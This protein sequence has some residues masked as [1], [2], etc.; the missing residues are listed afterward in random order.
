MKTNWASQ[1][2]YLTTGY[3][4][5]L[6][7]ILPGTIVGAIYS[8]GSRCRTAMMKSVYFFVSAWF[9]RDIAL[10][11]REWNIGLR[12]Y[13]YS[14]RPLHQWNALNAIPWSLVQSLFEVTTYRVPPGTFGGWERNG[15]V[16][17]GGGRN[18]W[19][20][21]LVVLRRGRRGTKYF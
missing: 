20:D 19:L 18:R 3:E 10:R 1:I 2:K 15:W 9:P 16:S 7:R 14:Y 11:L 12:D 5:P 8:T 6:L 21:R 4:F 13:N 17:E